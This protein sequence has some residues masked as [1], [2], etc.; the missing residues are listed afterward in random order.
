MPKYNSNIA[1]MFWHLC[2][3]VFAW[4]RLV[5][6]IFDPEQLLR[7][8]F[9]LWWCYSKCY[10]ICATVKCL[11]SWAGSQTIKIA[12]LWPLVEDQYYGDMFS[13]HCKKLLSNH[14]PKPT[15]HSTP[16][17]PSSQPW[18]LI[19]YSLIHKRVTITYIYWSIIIETH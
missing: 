17:Q 4:Q 2:L 9:T 12:V 8:S 5:Q 10:S 7:V 14:L 15:P 3:P 19:L 1:A 16:T 6:R 13:N 11:T 18:L